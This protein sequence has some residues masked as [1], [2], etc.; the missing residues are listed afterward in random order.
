MLYSLTTR[1]MGTYEQTAKAQFEGVDVV[2]Y[3][4]ALEHQVH[5]GHGDPEGLC[6]VLVSSPARSG[7]CR[8]GWGPSRRGFPSS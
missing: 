5:G 3:V 4:R 2:E 8:Q 1:V 6:L 7:P